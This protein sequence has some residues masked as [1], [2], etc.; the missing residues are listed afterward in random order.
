MEEAIAQLAD[1]RDE[2]EASR[3]TALLQKEDLQSRIAEL[4]QH[5]EQTQDKLQVCHA[6][7]LKLYSVMTDY[8]GIAFI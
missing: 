6:L 5:I 1:D 4:E 7:C 8:Q 2:A 3:D